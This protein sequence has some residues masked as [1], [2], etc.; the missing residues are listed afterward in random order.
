MSRLSVVIPCYRDAATLARA[1]LSLERQTR[2]ADEIIVVDDC[3]PE[4]DEIRRVLADFPAVS[5]LRNPSNLGLAGSRNEGLRQA[6]GEWVAFLDADDECHPQ[7]LELQLA[8]VGPR[9]AVACDVAAIAAGDPPPPSERFRQ[10]PFRMYGSPMEIAYFNRLTGA[11]LL[12]PTDL[13]RSFGG[14]DTS[15]RSC[16]DFDLWLRLLS[17]GVTVCR[18][19]LPLYFYY[20]NPRGL[21]KNYSSIGRWELAAVERLVARGSAGPADSW[22]VG[23]LWWVWIARQ[24]ARAEKTGDAELRRLAREQLPRLA[25]W[26]LMQYSLGLLASFRMLGLHRFIR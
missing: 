5:Y 11:S 12:A 15:L 2:P 7:R 17:G 6:T 14:Y 3:S 13:L 20:E 9:Q 22:R 24:F 23:L 21:S 18:V 16:E 4:G 1:L 26:P 8:R 19:R 10:A 25:P